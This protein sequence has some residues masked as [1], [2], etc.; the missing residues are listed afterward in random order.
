MKYYF[1]KIA[2]HQYGKN[3][4]K[5][6]EDG[7][8]WRRLTR[9]CTNEQLEKLRLDFSRC[10]NCDVAPLKGLVKNYIFIKAKLHVDCIIF[11]MTA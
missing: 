6:N 3:K 4:P 1:R 2:K 8:G 7:Q 9:I 10:T 11:L 5:R